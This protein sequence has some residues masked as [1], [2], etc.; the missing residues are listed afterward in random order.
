VNSSNTAEH[1]EDFGKRQSREG[2]GVRD[3]VDRRFAA[4]VRGTVFEV[5]TQRYPK[6]V[7]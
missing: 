4:K 2:G 7:T 3:L 6:R 5:A 1:D